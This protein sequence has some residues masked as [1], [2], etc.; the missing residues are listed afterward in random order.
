[1]TTQYSLEGKLYF[2]NT[3][4]EEV[5]PFDERISQKMWEEKYDSSDEKFRGNRKCKVI[6]IGFGIGM[7]YDY[8]GNLLLWNNDTKELHRH[9]RYEY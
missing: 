1:M 9:Y 2:F 6:F 3:E 8:Q 4:T 5:L 7:N